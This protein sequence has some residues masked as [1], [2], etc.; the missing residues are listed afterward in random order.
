MQAVIDHRIT[1]RLADIVHIR[2]YRDGDLRALVELVNQTDAIEPLERSMSLREWQEEL[3][4]PGFDPF[5]DLFVAETADGRLVGQADVYARGDDGRVQFFTW[6]TVHAGWRHQGIGW[7][8]MNA[9]WARSLEKKVELGTDQADFRATCLNTELG[10][11]TLFERFGMRRERV[12]YNMVFAPLDGNLPEPQFPP[13]IVIRHYVPG[14]DDTAW[15]ATAN[16]AFRDHWN[17]ID[18]PLASWQHHVHSEDFKPGISLIAMDGDEIA[19]VCH[20]EISEEKNRQTGRK[21]GLVATLGVRRPWRKRGLGTAL[22]VAS[23][24]VLRDAGMESAELGVDSQS[25]TGALAL[26]ERVGFRVRKRW[27]AYTKPLA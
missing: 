3:D 27:L 9:M 24:R 23:L 16:E 1:G 4:E 12:F 8:L 11:Q 13:G 18:R 21:E 7:R 5:R 26:Y 10:R 6:G 25:L 22:L 17:H 15:L 20:N 14:Q 19:G 2:N